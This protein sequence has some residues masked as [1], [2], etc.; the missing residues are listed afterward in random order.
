MTAAA[1]AAVVSCSP[2]EEAP[3]MLSANVTLR[4]HQENSATKT[5]VKDAGKEVYWS[6]KDELSIITAPGK[7]Y[8]FT[9]S[10]TNPEL[11][12]EFTGTIPEGTPSAYM[13]VYPYRADNDVVAGSSKSGYS[14]YDYCV[15]SYIPAVQG[16]VVGS[17]APNTFPSVG[18]SA[19]AEFKMYS[20]GS[21][22]RFT[23]LG[24]KIK[25][26]KLYG[27]SG[28]PLAGVVYAG[29]SASSPV[30]G[31][32]QA[33]STEVT[34]NAPDGS[35]LTPGKE[36][37]MVLAPVEMKKGFTMVLTDGNGSGTE[38]TV[39]IPVTFRRGIFKSLANA[40]NPAVENDPVYRIVKMQ[41]WGGTGPE[42]DCTKVYNLLAKPGCFN[43]E[44]GRGITALQDNYLVFKSDG[45]FVNYAGEDARQWWF[46]YSG[47]QNPADGKDVDLREMYDLLPLSEGKFAVD[48]STYTFTK[49]DGTT[50]TAT[51]AP[52]GTYP[53]SGTKPELSV[54]TEHEAL[55]FTIQGGKD[56]WDYPWQDYGV[57][58]CHPRVLFMELEKM[59]STFTVPEASRTF[60]AD[61]KYVAPEDPEDPSG[62][63]KIEDLVGKWNVYGGNKSPFG[64]WVLGGSGDDPAFVSPIDKSWDWND[65]IWRESD[66]GLVIKVTSAT[67]TTVTGTTNWWSG[68][69]GKFWDYIWKNTGEDLSRFYNKIP[70]GEHEFTLD[71]A[72]LTVTLGNG[73]EAKVL[74]PG[75]HEFVYKKT[76]E[77][78]EGCFAL[79]FHLGDPIAATADRWKDVDRFVN[80]PL[81]YV[82]IFEK[83]E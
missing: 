52:A 10:N 47:E 70:K 44:D 19:S 41:L 5:E 64:I 38:L 54:T 60:D 17:F 71:V 43:S 46:V 35:Y 14:D 15:S 83:E 29:L 40:D 36:Y 61:F 22:L 56:N 45:T 53:M 7:N 30:P 58:A 50:T 76:R 4:G 80:A 66:N 27:N 62:N 74:L 3:E 49:S 78:P 72:S 59:P 63:F 68:A 32:I 31:N 6:A 75:T 69:D 39:E 26:V 18:A 55:V 65:S 77:V 24:S 23:V 34:L 2:K 1:L 37:F 57:I 9:S 79:N 21:G 67:Q 8:K 81:E 25:S 82:I 16:A 48:G 51:W 13:A 28:E 42:Y 73:N 33:S 11:S 12:A 20:L